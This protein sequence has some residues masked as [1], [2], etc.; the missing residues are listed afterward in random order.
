MTIRELPFHE[1]PIRE[2]LALDVERAAP[3][4]DYA[5]Y[6]W[7]RV[8]EIWLDEQRVTDA[9]VLAIHTADDS[10]P[11]ADDLELEFELPGEKPV[12]VLASQFLSVWLPLLPRASAVV[13]AVCNPHHATLPRPAAAHGP[14]YVAMGD[15]ESWRD[16]DRG[17][18]IRLASEAG[19][20]R[21][22]A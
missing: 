11:I 22:D 14:V 4:P 13:L 17:D 20:Q 6:G 15:V 2:L 21:L 5:G 1:R 3:D 16:H 12:S 10:E 7:A 8:P 18:R 9:L 19:W